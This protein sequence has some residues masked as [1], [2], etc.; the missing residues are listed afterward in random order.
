[1]TRFGFVITTCAATLFV[2]LT[3]AFHPAPKLLWNASASVPIGLYAVRRAFPLY[4]DELVVVVPPRPLAQ[5]FAV[6]SYLPFGV[7]LLKHILA[8]P[9]Q[10]VCRNGR[11]VTVDGTVMGEAL[12]RDRF[13]RA[14]PDWQGCRA[15]APGEMF[16]MNTAPPDSLDGRYFGP[17]PVTTIVGRADPIWTREEN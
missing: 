2:A 11:A 1:M 9:G 10:T 17:L 12:D 4:I 6:R 15:L 5:F 16:V 8:L 14:L 7:P 3:S 13:G